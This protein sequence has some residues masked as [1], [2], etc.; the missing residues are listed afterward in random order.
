MME[1]Q[2]LTIFTDR[3]A[4]R[5]TTV[6]TSMTP[7]QMRSSTNSNAGANSRP[8]SPASVTDEFDRSS[9]R[10]DL[11]RNR[12]VMFV[13]DRHKWSESEVRDGMS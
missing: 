11:E 12:F 7:G 8:T 1:V 5:W 10:N 6:E 3:S 4:A 13:M 2:R 9:L